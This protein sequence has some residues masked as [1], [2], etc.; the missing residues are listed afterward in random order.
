[1]TITD[2]TAGISR[3]AML[4]SLNISV[5]TGRKMDRKTQAEVVANKGAASA[6]AASVYKSLFADCPELEAIVKFQS[7]ARNR[8]YDLTLPW[9]DSG[10]RLLPT[11]AFM[12]Y[13]QETDQMRQHFEFLVEQFLLKFDTL[14]AAAAFKLGTMFDRDEYPL[15]DEV[16]GR[17]RFDVAYMPLPTSGDFR[18][19]IEHETQQAL[20]DQYEQRMAEQ[21]AAAQQD[22]WTRLYEALTHLKDKL[23]LDEEGKRK[24]FRDTTVTNVQEL[25][26]ALTKLNVT[27]DPA[28]EAARRKLEDAILGVEPA[29]LRKEEG[30]RLTVL[31][32]VSTILDSFDFGELDD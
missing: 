9:S 27:G 16:A 1:M 22:A 13:T 23:T 24:I 15:R 28:L 26:D 29:E 3:A 14:V 5:Y 2:T 17:F 12:D 11:K 32:K 8:H 10:I 19:D 20:V 6:R 18:L 25:C 21:V 7:R 30:E 4:V 31:H